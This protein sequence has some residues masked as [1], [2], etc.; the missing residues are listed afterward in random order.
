V[1]GR[2][3]IAIAHR[4]ST[5]ARRC[6]VVLERGKIGQIGGHQELIAADGGYRSSA[7]RRSK[8]W[9]KARVAGLRIRSLCGSN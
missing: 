8:R 5:C 3:T 1:Q 6:L 4:L 2:T 9:L 7:P